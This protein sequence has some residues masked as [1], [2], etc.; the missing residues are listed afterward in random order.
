MTGT[1]IQ[2][3]NVYEVVESQSLVFNQVLCDSSIQ[4]EKEK[5][6]ANQLLQSNDYLNKVA[7]SNQASLKN[8]IANISTIGI[9][10]NPAL[11]HAY[12]VPRDGMVCLDISYIGLMHLAQRAG[13]ILWGQ[14][15]I[16]R[17]N[18][19]YETQ[20]IDLPPL[21]K[22]NAFASSEDRGPIVGAYCVVKT[23]DGSYLTDQ[24]TLE[25]LHKV[26]SKSKA[27]T[28]GK[29]CPWTEWT[30]EMMRKTVVKRASKYWP[31]T[32]RLDTAVNVINQHEGIDFSPSS[33]Q[34]ATPVAASREQLEG[35]I[36]SM[37]KTVEQFCKWVSNKLGRQISEISDLSDTE[38]SQIFSSMSNSK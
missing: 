9:S 25:E 13:S 8:A 38:I 15:Q 3:A 14:S 33:T 21:H 26:R 1:E 12:L 24:M 27:F 2:P 31:T 7:W 29:K 35:Q 22:Y 37:G 30:E 20:G 5:V 11:K 19:S 23:S 16:V 32:D 6:F 34:K 4:W 10:L 28:S 36:L 17:Q 18:D